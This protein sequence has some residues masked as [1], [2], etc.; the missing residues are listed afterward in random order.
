MN[1]SCRVKGTQN[2]KK[3][4]EYYKNKFDTLADKKEWQKFIQ[5]KME[6]NKP[7]PLQ[8]PLEKLKGRENDGGTQEFY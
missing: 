1:I 6:R 2:A 8:V 7:P 4:K 3:N 5:C